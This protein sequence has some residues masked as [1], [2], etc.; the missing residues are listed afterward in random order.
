MRKSTELK[1]MFG[2]NLRVLRAKRG[3][4]IQQVADALGVHREAYSQ[5]ERGIAI[6]QPENRKNVASFYGVTVEELM[7]ENGGGQPEQASQHEQRGE[8]IQMSEALAMFREL[9][10][11]FMHSQT[12]AGTRLDELDRKV[13]VLAEAMVGGHGALR[14]E[15]ETLGRRLAAS[16]QRNDA[17]VRAML[18]MGD[19]MVK[20][21]SSVSEAPAREAAVAMGKIVDEF[22]ADFERSKRRLHPVT[23]GNQTRRTRPQKG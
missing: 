7:A 15:V 14:N 4:E 10:G 23:N 12:A 20:M 11:P 2:R 3:L 17:I 19:S 21:A 22:R 6:P 9:I 5:W 13:T 8:E 1:A 16:E 18:R